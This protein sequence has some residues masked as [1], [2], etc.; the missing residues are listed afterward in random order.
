M[1]NTPFWWVLM[2]FMVLLDIYFFQA[3]K[4]VTSSAS[5]RVKTVIYSSYWVVS[6]AALIILL[7]L[8]YIH[9][10]KQARMIRTSLFSLISGLFFA[11]LIA[12][13]FFFVDDLRRLVQWTAGKLFF[14]KT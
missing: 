6:I 13:L 3:L 1:R 8:P 11:K 10:D 7:V 9:F 2:V 12:C 5:G 14:S 4:I